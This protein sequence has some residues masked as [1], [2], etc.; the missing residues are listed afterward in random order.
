MLD[1][2]FTLSLAAMI[3]L[4]FSWAFRA[5]PKEGWQILACLPS[6]KGQDG[7]WHGTNLTY[8]GFFNALAVC[9][10]VAIFLILMGSIKQSADGTLVIISGIIIICLPASRLIASLIEKKPHT[11]SVGAASFIG[12]VI[13]PW[14]ILLTNATLGKSS[15]FQISPLSSI[16]ALLIAYA[17]GEGIGRLACISFGCCYGKPLADCSQFIKNLFHKYHFVFNGKTKKIAYAHQLDGQKVIPVQALTATLY[18]LA[19]ISGLY[20]FLKGFFYTAMILTLVVTQGW[21]AFS[22]FLRADYRGSGRISAYQIMAVAA[23]IYLALIALYLSAPD[24][25][26]PDLLSGLVFFWD[27]VIIILL[28]ILW[29][30]VF[31]YTGRSNVTDSV[32]DIS[33]IKKNI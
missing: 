10:A 12:I 31:F 13:T 32:I 4:I 7:R 20:L 33:V 22:E 23:T 2:I 1:E 16:A 27:P 11:S 6:I 8:Y 28:T 30:A 26:I 14:I 21:R 19:A 29:I 5:L 24:I 18:V 3:A 9:V 15:G 17:F 25:I